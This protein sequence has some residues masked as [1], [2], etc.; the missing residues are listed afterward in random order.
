MQQEINPPM[1]NDGQESEYQIDSSLHLVGGFHSGAPSRAVVEDI[2]DRV[3]PDIIAIESCEERVF[4][5]EASAPNVSEPMQK[6]LNADFSEESEHFFNLFQE[7]FGVRAPGGELIFDYEYDS[8]GYAMDYAKKRKVG[9]APVDRNWSVSRSRYTN[10]VGF[11]AIQDEFEGLQSHFDEPVW[12][13]RDV[14]RPDGQTR[15]RVDSVN[16]DVRSL[17]PEYF[18][19]MHYERDLHMALSI[20]D[21]SQND[22]VDSIVVVV[23]ASH[24]SPMVEHL[25]NP[26]AMPEWDFKGPN[27]DIWT[28]E[29]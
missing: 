26:I 14:C 8:F 2:L 20:V 15:S 25:Q 6:M 1:I 17:A 24:L 23:G 22:N 27:P 28:L 10:L 13:I 5:Q 11:S 12:S 21:L 19:V 4:G 16:D 7:I 29:K 9:F 18:R 3:E